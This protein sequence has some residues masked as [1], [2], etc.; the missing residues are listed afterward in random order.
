MAVARKKPTS[1]ADSRIEVAGFALPIALRTTA[2]EIARSQSILA[3]EDDWDGEGSPSYAKGTWNRAIALLVDD[4]ISLWDEHGIVV[5]SPRVLAG[6]H[7]SIDLHWRTPKRELL[8]NVPEDPA[9]PVSYYGDDGQGRYPI[10]GKLDP[11]QANRWL[12]LWMAE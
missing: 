9:E 3:L 8:V 10:E 6:P 11:N 12:L 5:A 4:A 1:S 7:G 2:E